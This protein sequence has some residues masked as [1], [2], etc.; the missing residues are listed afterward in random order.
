[1]VG[2]VK[3]GFELRQP[4]FRD[5]RNIVSFVQHWRCSSPAVFAAF[6]GLP[7]GIAHKAGPSGQ[8]AQRE[9]G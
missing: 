4:V 5:C 8:R 9:A 2:P 6:P 3:G 7:F 1:M